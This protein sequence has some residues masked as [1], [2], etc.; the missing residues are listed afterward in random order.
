MQQ[1]PTGAAAPE[2]PPIAQHIPLGR[3]SVPYEQL[4][5]D[6]RLARDAAD[7]KALARA[8]RMH[9]IT[10]QF[11][12]VGA[13]IAVSLSRTA[14]PVCQCIDALSRNPRPV[15][16]TT[17]RQVVRRPSNWTRGEYSLRSSSAR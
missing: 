10:K 13:A 7:A 3:A 9:A 6:E 8:E 15:R 2:P 12:Q 14:L 4:T 17:L 16:R 11:L 1:E 5:F